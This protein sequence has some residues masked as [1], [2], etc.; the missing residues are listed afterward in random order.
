[1]LI[2]FALV[3][4]L[5]TQASVAVSTETA[6]TEMIKKTAKQDNNLIPSV[7]KNQKLIKKFAKAQK[8]FTKKGE[9]VDFSDPVDKWMWFW[10]FGWGAGLVLSIVATAVV[11]SGGFGIF[12][13]LGS[14]CWLFGTVSLV[15]WL[16][17]KFG[18]A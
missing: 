2:L 8:H 13:L 10:I 16:V 4:P 5:A 1:M 9:K 17:K 11:L 7:I 14:L 12:W 18:G 6:R 15:I 3:L